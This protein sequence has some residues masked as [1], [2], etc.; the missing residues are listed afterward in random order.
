MVYYEQSSPDRKEFTSGQKYLQ[1]DHH[2]GVQLGCGALIVFE[3]IG[4][5]RR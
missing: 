4:A 3:T 2:R 5:R 1:S